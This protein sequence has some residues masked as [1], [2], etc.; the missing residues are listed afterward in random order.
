[1]FRRLATFNKKKPSF[2]LPTNNCCFR[3]FF[4][5]TSLNYNNNNSTMSVNPLLIP[6]PLPFQFPPFDKIKDEHFAPAFEEAMKQHREEIE[7]VATCTDAPTFENTILGLEESGGVLHRI[8]ML[9]SSLNSCNTNDAL[10]KLDVEISPKLTAHND[11]IFLDSRIFNRVRELY[12]KKDS[13]GLDAES[14]RLLWRYHLDFVRA[15]AQL[16]DADKDK[17]KALNAELATL[18]TKMQQA[19][20]AE[21]ADSAVWFD[22]E[23][24]LEG[25]TAHELESAR[26]AS[27]AVPE[28]K[29]K[30]NFLVKLRNTTQQPTFI[31]LKRSDTRK[32]IL[33]ASM[34]R[35]ARGGEHDVRSTIATIARKRAE[36]AQ[37][38]GFATHADYQLS[39]EMA[40][41]PQKAIDL[42]ARLA[43]PAVANVAKEAEELKAFRAAKS[44]GIDQQEFLASDWD[45]YAE[46]LRSEKY[47]FDESM[48]KPYFELERVVK[49][50]Y[51][52]AAKCLYGVEFSE[53]KDLPVYHPT[54]RVFDVKEEDG[55]PLGLFVL[56]LYARDNKQGGAW[57]NN[58]I[59]QN[60]SQHPIV[61]NHLNLDIPAEGKPT[62][63]TF[64]EVVTLFHEGGHA[65]HGLLSK[66]KY[67]R[68]E[69]T[70]VPRDLV[71]LPSQ[72]NE[73]F[74]LFPEVIANCYR[75]V[76]T[77]EPIPMELIAKVKAASKF[78][79]GY[80]TTEYLAA[81]LLDQAW[82][83]LKPED[84]PDA[85]NVEAFEA[86]ALVRVG[87]K[88]ELVPPRYRSTYFSHIFAGGYSASYYSYIW[89]EILDA[90]AEKWFKDN[91][92]LTRENGMRFR[93]MVLEKGGS[94]DPEKIVEGFLSRTPSIDPLLE[95]RGLN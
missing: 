79:Q 1:M 49:D 71:E 9:F 66:V 76:D 3:T 35:G 46:Q 72:L 73:N 58:Y 2:C 34:A 64:D 26:K 60:K 29:R 14:S 7:R 94:E 87:L 39:D 70:T 18:E 4:S 77:N 84:V 24:E 15:G 86:A 68:F 44:V 61:G 23:E 10:Q 83:A 13:L 21:V 30:S 82:H 45:H 42:L 6:S 78:N 40:R 43:K 80:A 54:V 89:S 85:A 17:L 59:E 75:H 65:L 81:A 41:T 92:G 8:N 91:G 52:Y 69:G 95:R 38:L 90:D 88:S 31:S 55:T 62:L 27:A 74:M 22:T 16:N 28:D 63:L 48:L 25:F 32:K 93:R 37:L 67:S 56:D 51:F 12:D 36:R 53:R 11:A 5:K 20:L 57:M 19:I 50:G 33:A 47:A